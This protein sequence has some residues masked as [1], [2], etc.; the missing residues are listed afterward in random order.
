MGEVVKRITI[1]KGNFCKDCGFLTYVPEGYCY[2]YGYL[3]YYDSKEDL[4]KRS[5]VCKMD[6]PDGKVILFVEGE[7]DEFSSSKT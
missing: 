6:Y 2:L 7:E 5:V 3:R 1:P 4:Y